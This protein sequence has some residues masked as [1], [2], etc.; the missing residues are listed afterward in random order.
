MGVRAGIRAKKLMYCGIA[1]RLLLL[2]F[3]NCYQAVTLQ[4]FFILQF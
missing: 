1:M 4:A 3:G 2:T